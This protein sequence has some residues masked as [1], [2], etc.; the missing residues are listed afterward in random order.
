MTHAQVKIC[1]QS[2]QTKLE[3][4]DWQK[5]LYIDDDAYDVFCVKEEI[6]TAVEMKKKFCSL[7]NHGWSALL[8]LE[9]KLVFA[10]FICTFIIVEAVNEF[11]FSTRHLYRYIQYVCT[12]ST[13]ATPRWTIIIPCESSLQYSN[14]LKLNFSTS[15]IPTWSNTRIF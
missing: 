6:W 15:G 14:A 13:A 9:R 10:R 1:A 2:G 8:Q 4:C 12:I 7:C 11:L 5:F 3:K